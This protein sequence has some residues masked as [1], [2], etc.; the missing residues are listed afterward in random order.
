MYVDLRDQV[1]QYSSNEQGGSARLLRITE[2]ASPNNETAFQVRHCTGPSAGGTVHAPKTALDVHSE[3]PPFSNPA[4][5]GCSEVC[6]LASRHL[7]G[8]DEYLRCDP[9]RERSRQC[10]LILIHEKREFTHSDPCDHTL[11]TSSYPSNLLLQFRCLSRRTGDPR[12]GCSMCEEN[13]VAIIST[14]AARPWI[15]L[16]R[17]ISA[18]PLGSTI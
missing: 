2:E 11:A 13:R 6:G 12:S 8:A 3:L 9:F 5:N 1:Y 14:L 10:Q 17:E 16:Q 4:R 7:L 18:L 15:L